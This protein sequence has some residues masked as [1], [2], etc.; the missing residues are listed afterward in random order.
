MGGEE[1]EEEKD[2]KQKEEEEEAVEA[3]ERTKDE[4]LSS[5]ALL[6]FVAEKTRAC[7]V[8]PPS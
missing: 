3:K 7:S 6:R 5:Y 8:V 2:D 1:E 4:K